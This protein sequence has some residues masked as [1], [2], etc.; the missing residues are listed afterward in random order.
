VL[1]LWSD[2]SEFMVL[3]WFLICRLV[4]VLFLSLVGNFYFSNSHWPVT[5]LGLDL[6]SGAYLNKLLFI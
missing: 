5:T 2:Q 6:F 3:L 4:R 1:C